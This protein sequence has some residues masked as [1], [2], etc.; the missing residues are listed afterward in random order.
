ME[1][2][3]SVHEVDFVAFDFETTG[4]YPHQDD[5]VEFGAVKFRNGQVMAEFRTFVDPKRSIPEEASKISGI[6]D[7]ML[8]GQPTLADVLPQF[9]DFIQGTV[10]IA[11][12]AGFDLGFLRAA[13]GKLSTSEISNFVIDTQQLAKKAYPG[14][15]SYSLQNLANFLAFPPNQAHRALDDAHMCMRLFLSC[16]QTLSFMGNIQLSEV[17]T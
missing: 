4:L 16:A 13:I 14:Q 5:I 15:K 8:V 12:N 2:T 6:T 11:H 3:T 9:L 7:N 1:K 10:L 17:L